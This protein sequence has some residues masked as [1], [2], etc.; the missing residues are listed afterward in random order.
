MTREK[1]ARKRGRWGDIEIEGNKNKRERESERK[2]Y[3]KDGEKKSQTGI[4]IP[5]RKARGKN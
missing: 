4:R 3:K 5:I 1:K 2:K